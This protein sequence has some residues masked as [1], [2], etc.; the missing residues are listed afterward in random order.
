MAT[1]FL[2]NGNDILSF[3]FSLK[4]L[5]PLERD[6]YLKKILFLLVKPLFFIFFRH[7]FKWK[8]SFGPLKSYISTNLSFWLLETVLI[9]YKPFAFIQSF[10]LLVDTIHEIKCKPF[11]KEEQYACSLK[12]FSWIFADIPASG[13]RFFRLKE[14]EFSSNPSSRLVYTDFDFGLISNRMV[15]LRASFLLLESNTEI[16]CKPVF[17][18]FFSS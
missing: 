13:S 4:P 18:N 11:F 10:F 14:T 16:R 5:L 1:D 3:I 6:Q 8:Q 12:S 15:L 17:F 9:I 7:R 2:F